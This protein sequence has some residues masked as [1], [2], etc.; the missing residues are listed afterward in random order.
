MIY[1]I[2]AIAIILLLLIEDKVT[3]ILRILR[4]RGE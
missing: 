2:G 4:R 3:T 1:A